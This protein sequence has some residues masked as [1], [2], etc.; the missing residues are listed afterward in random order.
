[1]THIRYVHRRRKVN[2]SCTR[3]ACSSGRGNELTLNLGS[4]EPRV[5]NQF[6]CAGFVFFSGKE[7]KIIVG[8]KG[9]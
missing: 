1:M 2:N 3:G 6:G 7:K 5:P 9:I 8:K 4:G